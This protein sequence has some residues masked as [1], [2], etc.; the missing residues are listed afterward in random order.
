MGNRVRQG[1]NTSDLLHN[2]SA[3]C[4]I[5]WTH[6]KHRFPSHHPLSRM[7]Q[8]DTWIPTSDTGWNLWKLIRQCTCPSCSCPCLVGHKSLLWDGPGPSFLIWWVCNWPSHEWLVSTSLWLCPSFHALTHW[9]SS[10]IELHVVAWTSS[11]LCLALA[12]ASSESFS[13]SSIL[14]KC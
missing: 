4:E 13:I 11:T 8:P 7:W 3:Q 12:A 10:S 2:P 1:V 5:I 14:D 9:H 6:E